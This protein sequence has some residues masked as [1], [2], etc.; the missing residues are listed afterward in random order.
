MVIEDLNRF[1][2]LARSLGND[3]LAI[4]LVSEWSRALGQ[5]NSEYQ[6][7]ES[8][9]LQWVITGHCPYIESELATRRYRLDPDNIDE[10]LVW[11]SDEEI[12]NEVRYLYKQSVKHHKLS[13]CQRKD[14]SNGRKSKTNILLRMIW[15]SNITKG[16]EE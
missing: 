15:Y 14:F 1:A 11:V 6:I 3:Y 2:E 12:A 13:I 4:K 8:K 5:D 16:K 10:L 9:L 7:A